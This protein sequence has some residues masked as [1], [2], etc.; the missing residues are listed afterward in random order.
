MLC[1]KTSCAAFFSTVPSGS[2][3]GVNV[4]RVPS[5]ARYAGWDGSC[6]RRLFPGSRLFPASRLGL[7]SVGRQAG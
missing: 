3:A 5:Y 4:A 2:T 1:Y 6:G 7:T